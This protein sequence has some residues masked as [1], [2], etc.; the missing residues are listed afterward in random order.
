MKHLFTALLTCAASCL[1]TFAQTDNPR[2]IYRMVVLTDKTGTNI[3][4][5]YEQ[6][7][8]CTDSV[9]LTA[10]VQQNRFVILNND[11]RILNYTGEEPDASNAT[12]TRIY[13]SDDKKFTLKWWST[14][15]GHLFFAQNDWCKEFYLA[16]SYSK[17]GKI[18]F[19][20]LQSKAPAV[21]KKNPLYGHWHAI[22][23]YDEL[24]DVKNAVKKMTEETP[25]SGKDIIILTP[26]HF[27]FTAGQYFDVNTD[28]KTYIG[29]KS[30]STTTTYKVYNLSK[31]YIAVEKKRNQFTDYELWKRI[32]DDVTPLNRI[33]ARYVN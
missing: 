21:D 9:T 26:Q 29:M 24:A 32:T 25:Y 7:K 23:L 11:A 31:D 22:G 6:Y 2:G 27:I 13:D 1:S 10:S 28:G 20:A 17:A 15:S 18:I 5:P 30:G 16:N 19:D 14:K 33:A 12:A 8:I 4:A 3:P